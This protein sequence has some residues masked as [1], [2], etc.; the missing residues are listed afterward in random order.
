MWQFC[1]G[2]EAFL[3]GELDLIQ[4]LVSKYELDGVWLDGGGSPA[5]YCDEC[6]RQLRKKGLDPFDAGVQYAHKE[7]LRQ[8]FLERIHQVIKKARPGCL[9]CPQ[10]QGTFYGLA[11]ARRSSII[12]PR[13]RSSRMRSITATTISRR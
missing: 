12:P 10:N 3:K 9:V 5:C 11:R 8:S 1:I 7:E 2:Q 4:E 13:R 6:L